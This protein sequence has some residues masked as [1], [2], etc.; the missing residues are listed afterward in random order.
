MKRKVIKL[1]TMG[2]V[3][4]ITTLSVAVGNAVAKDKLVIAVPTFLTG[5]GAPAF[6]I[7]ARNGTELIIQAIRIM[8][9]LMVLVWQLVQM[10]PLVVSLNLE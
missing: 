8:V 3:A 4:V 2:A 6:G 10:N 5:G 1:A 9:L 7:P